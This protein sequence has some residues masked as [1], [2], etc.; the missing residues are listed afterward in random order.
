VES[1]P[2]TNEKRK[3]YLFLFNDLMIWVK[4]RKKNHLNFQRLFY[5][6]DLDIRPGVLGLLSSQYIYLFRWIH[7]CTF[8]S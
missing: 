3:V 8:N 6:T 1:N 4:G 7:D 2:V 5:L